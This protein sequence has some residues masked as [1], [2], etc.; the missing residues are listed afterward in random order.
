MMMVVRILTASGPLAMTLLLFVGCLFLLKRPVQKVRGS[1]HK[2]LRVIIFGRHCHVWMA[3][4]APEA[5][6]WSRLPDVKMVCNVHSRNKLRRMKEREVD[7]RTVIIPL[8][9]HHIAKCPKKYHSLVPCKRAL[10]LLGN[11]A[12]FASYVE[13]HNLDSFVPRHYESVDDIAWPAVLKRADLNSGRGIEIVR[14]IEHFE[15]LLKTDLWKNQKY[16]LQELIPGKFDYVTHCICKNGRI[17]WASTFEYEMSSAKE[18][19]TPDNVKFMKPSVASP[20][21]M[22][23]MEKLLAPL[24][25]NGP[26]NFDYKIDA[27]GEMKVFEIN[28]RLGGSLMLP[29]NV[30][31]LGNA[32]SCII[33]N[34]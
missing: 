6:V 7:Y 20:S 9:E 33:D 15:D 12:Q 27:Q 31:H 1:D 19:R 2:P 4:L 34:V 32:L 28:P 30:D 16:V 22:N 26:C 18:I 14:S 23:Q 13:R 29:E 10:G 24:R 11:K 8:M 25:F 3:A 21:T 17:L 5:S